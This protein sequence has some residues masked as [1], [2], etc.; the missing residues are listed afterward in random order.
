MYA[1]DKWLRTWNVKTGELVAELDE[2]NDW[3][4]DYL[5]FSIRDHV[6]IRARTP[7]RS[8]DD[9]TS[10]ELIVDAYDITSVR[11][12]EHVIIDDPPSL[13]AD[14]DYVPSGPVFTP[15]G[16]HVLVATYYGMWRIR[17]ADGRVDRIRDWSQ[18][19]T[20]DK[21][22]PDRTIRVF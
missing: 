22:Y 8:W 2:R 12:W 19:Y 7:S 11:L 21:Q 1:G 17:V 10:G 5:W 15:N 9:E 4:R 20:H 16:E 6:L 14:G 3:S 13:S 18:P